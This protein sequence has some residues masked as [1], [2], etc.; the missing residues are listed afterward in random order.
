MASRTNVGKKPKGKPRKR[1]IWEEERDVRE[2]PPGPTPAE[3]RKLVDDFLASPRSRIRDPL[4]E[5]DQLLYRL[6]ESPTTAEKT[7]ISEQIEALDAADARTTVQPRRLDYRDQPYT[8]VTQDRAGNVAAEATAWASPGG[9]DFTDA[10]IEKMFG[11][12]GTP[13]TKEAI[14]EQYRERLAS[15]RS[16]ALER[17][18]EREAQDAARS[19][20]ER[21][22]AF[23]EGRATGY[24]EGQ[25]TA[26]GAQLQ[27]IAQTIS[28]QVTSANDG[29]DALAKA[30]SKLDGASSEV[31]IDLLQELQR[32]P[33]LQ[34]L[35]KAGLMR[36]DDLMIKNPP[37]TDSNHV[38]NPDGDDPEYVIDR[39]KLVGLQ[40]K[41]SDY[42]TKQ[43]A[44]LS[45]VQQ[46]VARRRTTPSVVPSATNAIYPG[47][48][49]W[50]PVA[51]AP[52]L[53]PG[54][55]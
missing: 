42:Q 10:D 54:A 21:D 4:S 31:R 17:A 18:R 44:S 12:S 19:D 14:D 53:K 15:L 46:A 50:T 49:V 8:S 30:S 47:M 33:Q 26:S 48:K 39:K 13:P 2:A 38:S 25:A 34:D 51:W 3:Q 27:D 40:R 45:N 11:P 32:N 1:Y 20:F 24:A 22:R 43:T 29:M 41:L 6:G 55:S 9:G 16:G 28:K 5:R 36:W 23:R 35:V 52:A 7:R 37:A